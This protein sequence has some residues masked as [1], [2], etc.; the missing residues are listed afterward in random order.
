MHFPLPS[1]NICNFCCFGFSLVFFLYFSNFR[2]KYYLTR[3]TIISFRPL[4]S[5]WSSHLITMHQSFEATDF[6]R[7]SRYIECSGTGLISIRMH[8]TALYHSFS[9]TKENQLQSCS[10]TDLRTVVDV[11]EEFLTLSATIYAFLKSWYSDFN[12]DFLF[13]LQYIYF[14]VILLGSNETVQSLFFVNSLFI[15]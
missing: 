15:L 2:L 14:F 10:Y 7:L 1:C 6:F 13:Y 12:T 5:G 4:L 11:M 8:R 3:Y 9:R